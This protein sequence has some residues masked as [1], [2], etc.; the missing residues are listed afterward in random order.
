MASSTWTICS[1]RLR[2]RRSNKIIR[3]SSLSVRLGNRRTP[4]GFPWVAN[5]LGRYGIGKSW[6]AAEEVS[7]FLMIW[8]AYLGAGLALR[9][10]R[11]AAIDIVF[12]KLPLGACRFIRAILGVVILVFCGGADGPRV[13]DGGVRLE[14]GDHG[15]PDPGR[16]PLSRH[17]HRAKPSDSMPGAAGLQRRPRFHHPAPIEGRRRC[18]HKPSLTGS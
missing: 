10:G 13:P 17:P 3:S 8:V 14:H 2:Q 18:T 11:N 9:E 4:N 16:H 12:E 5:V 1:R 7:T 15:H 6:A